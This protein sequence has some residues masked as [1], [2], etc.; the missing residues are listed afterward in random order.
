MSDRFSSEQ[1]LDRRAP[2]RGTAECQTPL[3]QIDGPPS[4][5]ER[6]A[7][8]APVVAACRKRDRDS[9]RRPR[10]REAPFIVEKVQRENGAE[11]QSQ[12]HWHLLDGVVIDSA[13]VFNERPTEWENFCNYARP[14]GGL[15]GHTPYE[16]LRMKTTEPTT[17][18]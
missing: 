1:E 4:R 8:R 16:R 15:G 14:H 10:A 6:L 13:K 9:D 17:P 18:A 3:F 11:F 7:L 5:S 12:F 2:R